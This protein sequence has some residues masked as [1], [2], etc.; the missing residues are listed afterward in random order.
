MSLACS[1]ASVMQRKPNLFSSMKPIDHFQSFLGNLVFR[2]ICAVRSPLTLN[3]IPDI[4]LLGV[5]HPVFQ[6][7]LGHESV[8]VLNKSCGLSIQDGGSFLQELQSVESFWL[9]RQEMPLGLGICWVVVGI[10]EMF[11]LVSS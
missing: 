11:L 7:F 9:L 8:T 10:Y 6:L 2:L 4:V 1:R 3:V 5:M